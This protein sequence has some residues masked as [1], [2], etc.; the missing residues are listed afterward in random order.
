M[1]VDCPSFDL[2]CILSMV[3]E[4]GRSRH[5]TEGYAHFAAGVDGPA[6][7]NLRPVCV[8]IPAGSRVRLSLAAAS[9]PAYPINPGNGHRPVDAGVE[10]A[11]IITL[12]LG[13]HESRLI[14]PVQTVNA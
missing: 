2:S 6:E 14:L 10:E 3:D 12:R 7:V 5:L 11:M 13:L 1:S 9:F 8:T 4:T